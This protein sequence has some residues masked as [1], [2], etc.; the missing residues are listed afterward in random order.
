MSQISLCGFVPSQHDFAVRLNDGF[1][2]VY[3]FDKIL[4]F[5]GM[6]F[7]TADVDVGTG[8]MAANS[9]ITSLMNSCVIFLSTHKKS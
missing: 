1:D 8:V 2:L 9:P 5:C 6:R 4:F 7:V 3:E